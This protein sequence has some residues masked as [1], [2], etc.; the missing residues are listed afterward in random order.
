MATN[1]AGTRSGNPVVVPVISGPTLVT[2]TSS[3]TNNTVT[4]YETRNG[5]W[6]TYRVLV[7]YTG[8][9]SAGNLVISLPAGRTINSTI[10]VNSSLGSGN[11]IPG[12]SGIFYDTSALLG[13]PLSVCMQSTTSV[14][15]FW[16]DDIAT[17]VIINNSIQ[18]VQPVTIATGDTVTLNFS[19]PILEWAGSANVAYGAG[20]VTSVK[21]GLLPATSTIGR[22]RLQSANGYGSTSTNIRRFSNN[23]ETVGTDIV[24]ADSATLG[25]S[26]TI[27]TGG[28]YAISYM[29]FFNAAANF[30]IS[31]NTSGVSTNIVS[32]PNLERISF[33]TA[34]GTNSPAT[35]SIT[36]YLA[37]GDIIRA[38]TDATPSGASSSL[39]W[40]TIQKLS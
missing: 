27:A 33:T 9:P 21:D 23:L 26:F 39:S 17:G 7:N 36:L 14:I 37:A 18:T 1:S 30:G 8:A 25:G 19:V 28:V 3:V 6:A 31:K 11:P 24:Y 13:W 20:R 22:V 15:P 10:M 35:Q 2:M 40:F 32:I 34:P 29:D 16:W 12:S 38:H 5:E 4:A